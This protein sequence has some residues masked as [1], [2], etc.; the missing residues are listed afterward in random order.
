MSQRLQTAARCMARRAPYGPSDIDAEASLNQQRSL[1]AL[2]LTQPV[3]Y[4]RRLLESAVGVR[5]GSESVG[6]RKAVGNT[7]ADLGQHRSSLGLA[8]VI[9]ALCLLCFGQQTAWGRAHAR[10]LLT[11][12]RTV[13]EGAA[14][15][16][17]WTGHHLGRNHKLVVQRPEGT[18][19]TWRSIMR[20]RTLSGSAELP[21]LAL[22]K[23]R[24]RLADFV[25]RRLLAQRTLGIAVFGQVPF[26]ALFGGEAGTYVT[27]TA[28]F[29]YVASWQLR[30][31]EGAT[32]PT[33]TAF[34][35]EHNHCRAVH[36]AFVLGS[37][38][39]NVP[40]ALGIATLVQESRDPT[41]ASAKYNTIGSLDATV[42]PSQSWA[43]NLTIKE[44][45]KSEGLMDLYING[46]AI[47]DSTEAFF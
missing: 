29:P 36:L 12:P 19:K 11:M 24:F 21:G 20:L 7:V 5:E 26:S 32:E 23:Y 6:R 9:T 38:P 37:G 35:V 28:S 22:G 27:P 39:Y 14:I 42:V 10:V 30:S 41:S 2:R 40:T 46:Y 17:S 31:W 1:L 18:A 25:G 43:V 44:N 4:R 33:E 15:P 45:A 16:F 34:T 3:V 47:C 8:V 13:D